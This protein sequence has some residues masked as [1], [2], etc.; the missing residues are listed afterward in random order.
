MNSAL[1][2][3]LP[4][5]PPLLYS[6]VLLSRHSPR[7]YERRA[8]ADLA[9]ST[10][11]TE[12]EAASSASMPRSTSFQGKGRSLGLSLERLKRFL[13]GSNMMITYLHMSC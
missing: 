1:P 3:K 4:V 13:A 9:P 6:S 7:K 2:S 8:V 5:I 10:P 12:S 11:S